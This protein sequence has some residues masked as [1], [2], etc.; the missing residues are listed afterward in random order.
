[1]ADKD[2]LNSDG[3]AT[4][5][6]QRNETS[7]AGADAHSKV[8]ENGDGNINA[9][10]DKGEQSNIG[11]DI[12]GS[13][14][15][16]STHSSTPTQN[17]NVDP[18]NKQFDDL[19]NQ[20]LSGSLFTSTGVCR[21][22]QRAT[23]I[24]ESNAWAIPGKAAPIGSRPSLSF[25]PSAANC[26]YSLPY[27]NSYADIVA[28]SSTALPAA[29][30]GCN[31]PNIE[32][33]G[34]L[35]TNATTSKGILSSSQIAARHVITRELPPFSGK[36]EEWLLFIS[37]YEQSTERCGFSN[38]ENLIRLQKCLKGP[39][40][41][42]VR[43]KLVI[44]ATVPYAIGT[45]K[46]LF[47]RPEIVHAALQRKLREEP[48]VRH[49]NLDSVIR[50]ALAVQNYCATMLAIGL[51]EYLNDPLLLNELVGKLPGDLKLDWGR[52]RLSAGGINLATFDQWLFNVA[53]CATM[54]TSYEPQAADNTKS[55]GGK[56]VKERVLVHVVEDRD[57]GKGSKNSKSLEGVSCP[58]C[59]GQHRLPDCDTFR[60]LDVKGRWEFVKSERLCFSCFMR[61]LVRYCKTKK[62][63]G[64]DGC[65]STHSTLLHSAATVGGDV[66]PQQQ[67]DTK[68][69]PKADQKESTVLFHSRSATKALFRYVPVTL[70]GKV[71]QVHTYA[72]ID[73]GS[74][75]TLIESKLADE[76]ELEGPTEQLC[77]KWTGDQTQTEQNSKSVY[78]NVSA[79]GKEEQR[80]LLKGVRTVTSLDL[81]TQSVDE[82]LLRQR[83]HLKSVPIQAYTNVKPQIIIGLDN[84]KVSVPIEII[85]AEDD[86]VIA[87]RCR[88]GWA[89]YGRHNNK[90]HTTP[91]ILHICECS[92]AGIARKLDEAVKTY[93]SLESMGVSITTKPLRS[94][95]D[96]RSLQIMENTSKYLANE[97]RWETGL[98]WRFDNIDLPDSY[99]MALK[100]LNCLE[101]K[102]AK[103]S[104]LNSFM[105]STIESYIKNG[106]VRKLSNGE[107]MRNSRS[108]FLPIFTVTNPNK[109]KT[110]LVWDAAAKVCGVALN[111]VLLKG[112]D[113]MASLIGVLMRFRERR[114]AITG[115]IRQ[116]FH[117]I[118]VRQ[119]DLAAQQFLWRDGEKARSPDVYVMQVMTF[120]AS[121]SPALANFIKN[122]NADRFI[123]KHPEAVKAIHK[124]T[125]VDDWL[126]SVDSEQQML[127]LAEIVKRIH[128]DGGFEMRHWLS[129]SRRVV[130]ALDDEMETSAKNIVLSDEPREKVL[131]MWWLPSEDSLTFVV[132][133]EL[134]AKASLAT[135]SKR[136]VL[137]VVMSIFDP[138]G[139]LGFFNIRAK[140][141]LQNIWRSGVGWD[142]KLKDDEESDWQQWLKL[143][144]K[145]NDVRIPRCMP[146]GSCAKSIQLHTFVDASIDAYAA[147]T[148]LRADMDDDVR[149][150]IVASKTRVA[151]LKPISI[152]RMELMAA[153]LGLRLSNCIE[154]EASIRIDRRFFWTDSRDV[155]CW[156]RS[157]ARKFQ[158][159]VA[160]RIGEIL[161]GSDVTS[162]NWVPSHHNVADDGTKWVK[163]PEINGSTRWF[164]GPNFLYMDESQWPQ[165][166]ATSRTTEANVVCHNEVIRT[167][168]C[169]LACIS[170]DPSRFSKLERLRAAQRSVLH[171]LRI[172]SKKPF[173][174]VLKKIIELKRD[175]EMDIVLIRICQEESFSEEIS[176]LK[177]NKQIIDRKSHLFKCSPY[178]DDHGILRIRGRVD[179]IEAVEIDVKRP[180]IL[181]RRHRITYLIAEFYHRKYHHLH[182]EI[183][184]NE[185]RQRYWISGL[186]ALVREVSK[187]CPACH[188]RKAQPSPPEMGEL[189][190]ERL[191]PHTRPFTF[192]GV[193]Y[194]GPI[195]IA[196]GR[197]REKRWG[198]LFTCLTT[199]A[200][201]L[202]IVP[203]L[204]TDSFLMALKSFTARRGVPKR[205]ISDNGT[206]F[207]GA[208]RVLKESIEC[209]SPNDI[210]KQ[211]P[212]MSFSFIPP[213]APHMGGAWERMV[214][215][216]KS[217]LTE[218]LPK[219]KLREEVLRATLADIEF[220]LNSRPLTYV[221]LDSM[222]AEAL[223]PNHFLV[224][225][226]NGLRE[227]GEPHQTGASLAKDFRIAG[228]IADVFW[229]RW[230]REYLPT[231]T[232]RTKW[233]QPPLAPIAVN[234][235]VIIVDENSKRC[236]WPKGIVVDIHHSKDGQ[237]RSAIVRTA[238]GLVTRPAVKLAKLDIKEDG[239]AQRS[240]ASELRGGE[241]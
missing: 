133:P 43:G 30:F 147:V 18:K 230:L 148:Y 181:P 103:D 132:K 62:R 59:K 227:R 228:Q 127:E 192:T 58:K 136:Q 20:V 27:G 63:C 80:Y 174:A 11:V 241:C 184:V 185:L 190:M 78:L 207:R 42:A 205:I 165:I 102:M 55:G 61:H 168:A 79:I 172:I 115:D 110:R 150:L 71:K 204:S 214:R 69:T 149:C 220:M 40:L 209:I 146:F 233:F 75:C 225:S 109:M 15:A 163:T 232:R 66:Q 134:I 167:R 106:Y 161:E 93:F 121:C 201:Y 105:I 138:L 164:I 49:N 96:E 107:I 159:F 129:N 212:E 126:Q 226:S 141:I 218:I 76:L 156:I 123:S 4:G 83:Y 36:P 186:R 48:A 170:P 142:D 120:G 119:E 65:T 180:I 131:G 2:V 178:L 95:E 16:S 28:P 17:T 85:E 128:A 91:R 100:R 211:Y 56:Q 130:R 231:L 196:V 122:K 82:Q 8:P 57:K 14:P 77:L 216:T 3:G 203:S 29:G 108:W 171:F 137:S 152:P 23:T 35:P 104:Q 222:D 52:H 54:V 68:A 229:K 9:T 24:E 21:D 208:S 87:V 51:S 191:S 86:D 162:W 118:K 125:F 19:V 239:N 157:D 155:L 175:V 70:Y 215:S 182:N 41:E 217:I 117:Q 60:A 37:N 74:A 114:V 84:I 32:F 7:S 166:D 193:D 99:Q 112:P 39:A 34:T 124:N 89:V 101:A 45:L 210:E 12:I 238:D 144:S 194:F 237:V 6:N 197:R 1:M 38:E 98:L 5:A 116:M 143:V 153:I 223:T 26:N 200:V 151:P 213:G 90:N 73:E 64:V 198:V 235:I 234:D 135:S 236:S 158:Q 199:R 169:V 13:L 72:L 177:S 179:A 173:E 10:T 44:P 195:D 176:C 22:T 47:G 46:M 50:L 88:L 94:K 113:L 139:L 111:D 92:D 25:R 187:Q 202:D 67:I 188:I 145:L 31:L 97:K 224:G 33:N 206:N 160:V 189:P 219:A 183:V 140:I 240:D 81:P 221:P 154:S 53:M